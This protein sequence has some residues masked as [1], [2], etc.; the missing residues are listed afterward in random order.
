MSSAEIKKELSEE[1]T[2]RGFTYGVLYKWKG[3]SNIMKVVNDK[4]VGG[5]L[6]TYSPAGFYGKNEYFGIACE[7]H[8]F[9]FGYNQI[10]NGEWA[11]VIENS[12]ENQQMYRDQVNKFNKWRHNTLE[13]V[14]NK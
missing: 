11:E 14:T 5:D 7:H 2:K 9:A 12:E 10:F 13:R 6:F 8:H 1:A 3:S 4:I